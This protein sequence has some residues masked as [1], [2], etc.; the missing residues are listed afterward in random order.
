MQ[1]YINE[2]VVFFVTTDMLHHACVLSLR[3]YYDDS[4]VPQALRE[5]YNETQ[6]Q[7]VFLIIEKVCTCAIGIKCKYCCCCYG[8]RMRPQILKT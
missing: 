1:V 8:G 6:M 3:L 2:H 4:D 7:D 5:T